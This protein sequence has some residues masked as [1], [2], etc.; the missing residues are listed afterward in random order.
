MAEL[1]SETGWQAPSI[2]GT[3]S[4]IL[5]K[6]RGLDVVSETT[7]DGARRYRIRKGVQP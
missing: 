7:T 6:D 1:M 3:L 5:R 4:S 2:R